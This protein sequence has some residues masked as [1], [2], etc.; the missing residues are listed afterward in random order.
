MSHIRVENLRLVIV[1]LGHPTLA[2]LTPYYA[3]I[4]DMHEE[5]LGA[6]DNLI[7]GPEITS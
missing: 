5:S 6:D 2:E 4:A 1:R 3:Y 7:H